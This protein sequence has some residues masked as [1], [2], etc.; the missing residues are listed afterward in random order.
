MFHIT[1]EGTVQG[2]EGT[3]AQKIVWKWIY[4]EIYQHKDHATILVNDTV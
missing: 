1:F 3:Y 2:I 4:P